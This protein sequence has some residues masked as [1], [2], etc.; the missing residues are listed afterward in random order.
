MLC[1]CVCVC[2]LEM[3]AVGK[4]INSD[5]TVKQIDFFLL[6]ETICV[7]ANV[8]FNGV[9][10]KLLRPI[11]QQNEKLYILCW[12]AHWAI[13]MENYYCLLFICAFIPWIMAPEMA[14]F[15]SNDR[16]QLTMKQNYI[17]DAKYWWSYE[18]SNYLQV[19]SDC[20]MLWPS[21]EN[22]CICCLHEKNESDKQVPV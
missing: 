11:I 1:V 16:N 2:L 14:P 17:F 22:E 3:T 10:L 5:Y 8:L 4:F 12:F 9:P 15:I 18:S 13:R 6:C 21:S 19:K 20:W 7:R